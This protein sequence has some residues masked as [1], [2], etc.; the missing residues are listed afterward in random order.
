MKDKEIGVIWSDRY[1]SRNTIYS[2]RR[3][4]K[5]L[6]SILTGRAI[7]KRH[8]GDHREILHEILAKCD[9]PKDEFYKMAYGVN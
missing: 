1:P 6:V 4:L 5:T 9:V 7:I 2:S 8:G 3:L